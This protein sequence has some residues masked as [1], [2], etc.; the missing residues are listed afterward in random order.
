LNL[1]NSKSAFAAA[2]ESLLNLNM[3]FEFAKSRYE[4]GTIDF[5]TY[6]QSLNGKNTGELQLV[7]TK[8]TILFRQLILDIYTGELNQ[9]N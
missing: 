5:V 4:N 7:Q 3:A 9:G 8:Y 2:K 6:L 1:V